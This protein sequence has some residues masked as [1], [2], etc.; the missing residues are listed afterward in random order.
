MFHRMAAFLYLK[1]A[2]T[3]ARPSELARVLVRLGHIASTIA[4]GSPLQPIRKLDRQRD[5]LYAGGL[6]KGALAA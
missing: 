1:C 3:I 2:N 6:R 5:C 4:F